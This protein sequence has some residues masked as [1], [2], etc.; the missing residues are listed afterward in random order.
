M[1]MDLSIYEMSLRQTERDLGALE[2]ERTRIR[3]E[4]K[5]KQAE[6]RD[7][8]MKRLGWVQLSGRLKRT[9]NLPLTEEEAKLCPEVSVTNESSVSITRNTFKA[10]SIA[11]AARKYL[12]MLGRGA[13]QRELI[14]ILQNGGV[15]TEAKHLDAAF[16]NSL[17]RRPDWFVFIREKGK[18][19]RWEL[20]EWQNGEIEQFH[21]DATPQT[22]RR[23]SVVQ[24]AIAAAQVS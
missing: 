7:L 1:N 20:T 19:G 17:V 14:E 12:L 24:P 5:D 15:R 9:L 4:I 8:G 2:D 21:E 10:M 22:P 6:L 18:L 13:T 16:R 23:L 11:D 3:R